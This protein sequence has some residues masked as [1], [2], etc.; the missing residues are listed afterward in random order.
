MPPANNPRV[1]EDVEESPAIVADKSPKST[2]LPSVA[3]V[4]YSIMFT[5]PVPEL[6]PA[7]IPLVSE[8]HPAFS[9]R[10]VDRFPKVPAVP[11]VAIV[12]RS[13]LAV[14]EPPGTFPPAIIPRVGEENVAA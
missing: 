9:P 5:L 6:P 10:A 14:H 8:E 1:F 4:M 7:I 12:T 2:E 3:M 13:I 11:V